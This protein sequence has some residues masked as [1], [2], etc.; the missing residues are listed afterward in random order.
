MGRCALSEEALRKMDGEALLARLRSD[1][2]P[3]AYAYLRRKKGWIDAAG[4]D[5]GRY[6]V[7]I[8][9]G[10]E[11]SDEDFYEL[12]ANFAIGKVKQMPIKG[13]RASEKRFG[14]LTEIKRERFGDA[15]FMELP[16]IPPRGK[17][18]IEARD[19]HGIE[20]V[21]LN[22]EL[23]P[24]VTVFPFLPP[25]FRKVAFKADGVSFVFT[26]GANDSSHPRMTMAFHLPAAGDVRP[27]GELAA[28]AKLVRML[29]SGPVHFA[30]A[31]GDR[32]FELAESSQ[33]ANMPDEFFRLALTIE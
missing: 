18:I 11:Q 33:E 10:A 25:R 31:V 23:Y 15:A 21:T 8:T 3:D 4:F 28:A 20:V 6:H 32:R 17:A 27:L 9:F 24:A 12:A 5:E 19:Q 13:L 2:G 16:A 1:V 22:C 7:T 29:R 30:V 26:P 14:I